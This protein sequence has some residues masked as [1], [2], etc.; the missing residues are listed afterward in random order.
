MTASGIAIVGAA[1]VTG[2]MIVDKGSSGNFAVY[3]GVDTDGLQRYPT[4]AYTSLTNGQVIKFG[5]N[6]SPFSNMYLTLP[7]GAIVLVNIALR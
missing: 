2:I 3:E 5:Q 6:A 4:T 7:T 1:L